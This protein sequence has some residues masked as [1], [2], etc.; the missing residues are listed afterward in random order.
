M[1][2]LLKYASIVVLLTL[3]LLGCG[4]T[5]LESRWRDREVTI[6]GNGNDW[7]GAT[8]YFENEN[9][10]IGLLNDQDF[11]YLFL[12]SD[13][14][15]IQRRLVMRGLTVWFD[16][17]GGKDRIFGI[18]F[19]LGMQDPGMPLAFREETKPD[20]EGF[21]EM[22]K[23]TLNELEI[24]GPGEHDRL[25]TS[26]VGDHGISVKLGESDEH[27]AY[28]LK[29]P[30]SRTVEHPHAIGSTAGKTIGVGFET[31]RLNREIMKDRFG[32]R[33]GSGGRSGGGMRPG[34]GPPGGIKRGPI[35]EGLELWAVVNLASKVES[36]SK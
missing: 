10:T 1:H 20:R 13:D 14:R 17:D 26:V 8:V 25:R 12:A 5:E 34:G 16:P 2:S 33:M 28:E 30:L 15:D 3:P 6:D 31:T 29:V 22:Y 11:L 18:R 23:K 9:M 35:A 32:G 7:E 27:L 19:P 24:I 36:H 4:D 21:N